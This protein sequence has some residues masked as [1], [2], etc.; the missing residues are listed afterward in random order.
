MEKKG[1]GLK[2]V[3]YQ[4]VKKYVES[5]PIEPVK[6]ETAVPVGKGEYVRPTEPPFIRRMVHALTSLKIDL[7]IMH[8]DGTPEI[9][10]CK[11]R[12][13][14]GAVGQL[15]IY[16]HLLKA[17]GLVDIKKTIICRSI[18]PD[19]QNVCFELGINVVIYTEI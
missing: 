19:V 7:L 12:A 14:A 6:V 16:E 2:R 13:R 9:C 3:E 5:L 15:I 8:R 1:T 10:E 4:Q 18:H 11:E 17:D